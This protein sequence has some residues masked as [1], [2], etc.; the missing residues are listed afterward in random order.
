MESGDAMVESPNSVI[1]D[2]RASMMAEGVDGW[3]MSSLLR[4]RMEDWRT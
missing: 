1:I 3:S 2:V 4:M